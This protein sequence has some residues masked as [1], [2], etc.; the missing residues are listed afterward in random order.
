MHRTTTAVLVALLLAGATACS[1]SDG[2][3]P[4]PSASTGADLAAK[5]APELIEANTARSAVCN[6]VGDQDCATH[7]TDIALV[8]T[9]LEQAIAEAGGADAYPRTTERIEEINEAVDAYTEHECLGDENAGIAGSPCP[10]DARTIMTGGAALQPS[11]E[12]DEAKNG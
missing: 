5:F 9:D 4:K 2:G 11:L 1:G 8:V 3:D 6:Q 10:D 7:L 12:A